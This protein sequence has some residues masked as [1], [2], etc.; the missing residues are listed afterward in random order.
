MARRAGYVCFGPAFVVSVVCVSGVIKLEAVERGIGTLLDT[1]LA[2]VWGYIS[3]LVF[4]SHMD[5]VF[6]FVM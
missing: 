4:G 2:Y 6:V 3:G 5:W 1:H